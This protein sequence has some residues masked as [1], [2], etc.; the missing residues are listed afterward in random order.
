MNAEPRT[1]TLRTLDHGNVT[2]P[3]PAWC[4]GHADH[5]PVDRADLTHSGTETPL[6][7]HGHTLWTALLSQYP[8]ATD[9]ATGLYVEQGGFALT[10]DPV[11]LYSLA[12]ALDTHADQLRA[13]ADQL[14]AIR[15]ADR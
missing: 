3:E 5:R 8:F 10:L 1:V 13:L 7:F 14:A 2:M 12:A 15:G 11:S 4:A 9:H 6:T